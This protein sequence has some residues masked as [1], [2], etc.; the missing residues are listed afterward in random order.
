MPNYGL[1]RIIPG[2]EMTTKSMAPEEI[3]GVFESELVR[4]IRHHWELNRN[5]KIRIEEELL[6]DLRAKNGRYSP[7]KL[8]QIG[9]QGGSAIYMMIT[10]TKMRAAASWIKDIVMPEDDKAWG[11]E[12]TTIPDLPPWAEQ[13]IHARVKEMGGDEVQA[14]SLRQ[15]LNV[16]L[17]QQAQTSS[18]A[19]ED[20]IADQLEESKWAMTMNSVIDDF[21][22][23]AACFVKG[24]TVKKVK[25]LK[26]SQGFGTIKPIPGEERMPGFHRVS[27]FD[28][29]PSPQAE[30]IDD[31]NLIEHVRFER[32]DLYNLLGTTGY[33]DSEI[34]E[35]LTHYGEGLRE[36]LW[37]DT[38]RNENER[39][40]N[41]WRDGKN[42]LIDALHYWGSVQGKTLE[43]WGISVDDPLGEHQ[44]EAILIGRYVIRV[45]I[46]DDPLG[47]R[48][49]HKACYDPVPGSFWGNSIRY[50]M[51][52]IQ[53]FCNAT[54]RALVNNMAMASGP[55]MEVNY[56]RLSPLEDELEI[57]PWKVWQTRGA[58]VGAGNTVQFFQP[59]SN[60]NELMAVYDRFEIKA[61]D[62]TSIPRYSHGNEK[63]GGAGTTASGL[64]M[65]MNSAAKGIKAAIQ[66]FDFGVTRP[67]IEMMYYYNMMTS[68]DMS[69]KGDAK[70]VARGANA[71]LLKDM[72]QSRRNE[73]LAITN[74]PID[75]GIIG[76]EG[77]ATILRAVANDFEMPGIVPTKEVIRMKIKEAA[78]NPQPSEEEIKMQGEAE[79][80]KIRQE[81]EAARFDIEVK[82]KQRQ[83]EIDL[84]KLTKDGAIKRDQIAAKKEAEIDKQRRDEAMKIRLME[85]ETRRLREKVEITSEAE[86]EKHS[87][88]LE[89]KQAE[90]Q[91]GLPKPVTAAA[92]AQPA[93]PAP[94]SAEPAE[95][96]APINLTLAI[97]NKSGAIKKSIKINRDGDSLM[98]GMDIEEVEQS[99]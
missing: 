64:S 62:A 55:M 3:E 29:Y 36:W 16:E 96:A 51:N 79:I 58:E 45:V 60:A 38:E 66:N 34:R 99:E 39:K 56:E 92:P 37:Q 89:A 12:P 24:P 81:G 13:A 63:V 75:M 57:Y 9:N 69:I 15:L 18:D 94:S 19:M 23:F 21:T 77:R 40:H 59:E 65:L 35:V 4:H 86:V 22:T 30:E 33:R 83:Q 28:I 27:P 90:A 82:F 26:W 54:A 42:G 95:P 87:L 93:L 71:L 49:Y 76:E 32:G 53:E 85:E 7:A 2:S 44:V 97:D 11:I 50:L 48:P 91:Y 47:R 14:D 78:E 70:V 5:S 31:G 1:I 6:E 25:T 98:T 61:D 52:D 72:A 46:N 10:A 43:E 67:G 73:F 88:S 8:A 80:E 20:K 68:K 74:N 41:W 84:E 17:N